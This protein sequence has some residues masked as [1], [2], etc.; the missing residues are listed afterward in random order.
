MDK[1]SFS[2]WGAIVAIVLV[3][4]IMMAFATPFGRYI[5]EG[6]QDAMFNIGDQGSKIWDNLVG[7]GNGAGGGDGH[8]HE[9]TELTTAM[10]GTCTTK[11]FE[12]YKC[13]CGETN[14]VETDYKHVDE[15]LNNLCDDCSAQLDANGEAEE[16]QP[17]VLAAG[18]YDEN[19]T[20]IETWDD[21]VTLYGLD[22]EADYTSYGYNDE[23]SSPW[24]VLTQNEELSSGV[25]LVIGDVSKIGNYAFCNCEN[26]TAITIPDSVTSIGEGSFEYCSDLVSVAIP[27]G[28]TSIG[29]NAFYNC[30]GLTS[31]TIPDSV[32]SVGSSA[33]SSCKM[34]E[35]IYFN[36]T[37]MN[38]L[39]SSNALFSFAGQKGNG[40]EVVIGK[41]VTT[42]PAN[43]F[44]PSSTSSHAPYITSVKFEEGSICS[45]IGNNAFRGCNSLNSITFGGSAEQWNSITKGSSWN[46]TVPATEVVCSDGNVA[47]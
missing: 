47:L 11:G 29:G 37:A 8:A 19:D 17:S 43:L 39:S 13:A 20:L 32:T 6:V 45:K 14:T 9:Y 31:V 40:I 1:Q 12:V 36:A 25:K 44:Y 26:L 18:L 3:I 28:V 46:R 30:A 22:V 7:G 41:N 2:S 15:D 33:F 38:D 24:F 16:E 34:L 21:L 5:V 4:A 42:I 27:S 23:E 35:K 10:D